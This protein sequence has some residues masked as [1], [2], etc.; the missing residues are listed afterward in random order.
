MAETIGW[1]ILATGG[2]AGAFTKDLAVAGLRAAAVGSRTQESADD[3]GERYGIPNRHGSYEAL[4]A[5]PDVDIV[6]ISTPHSHHAEAALLALEAGKHVL[7]E[8][9]FTLNAAQARQVVA[10]AAEKNLLVLEAM[11]TRFLPHMLRLHEILDAGTLGDVRTVIADHNQDTPKDPAHR[12]NNPELGGGALLDLGV[13]PVSFAVDVLGGP[14]SVTAVATFTETGVDRQTAIILEHAGGR[15]SVLHT[16]LD[17]RGPNR[18]AVIGALGRIELDA[19][20]YSPTSFTVYDNTGEVVERYETAIEGRGMQ[21]QA[22]E[23]ER[24]IRVGETASPR[25]SPAESVLVMDVLD[26][27]RRRIG[28]TYPGETPA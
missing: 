12:M 24:L 25:L 9:P 22:L 19:V 16:A 3:F 20:W 1:G 4:V 27:V 21:F 26:D 18:A 23:A 15:Q 10:L 11:W 13:Y 8:K 6:Y 5:D 14:T 17:T 28:L 2:I 7:V